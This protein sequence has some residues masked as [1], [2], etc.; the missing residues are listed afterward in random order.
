ML[1]WACKAITRPYWLG[2]S[3]HV[4]SYM[5]TQSKRQTMETVR[6]HSRVIFQPRQSD[7]RQDSRI[8]TAIIN[9]YYWG[10]L[11]TSKFIKCPPSVGT[12]L[13]ISSKGEDSQQPKAKLVDTWVLNTWM[14]YTPIQ[15]CTHS[16]SHI[17]TLDI[18]THTDSGIQWREE[19]DFLW[20]LV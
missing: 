11:K 20:E 14:D 19:T 17:K 2:E 4:L 1:L 18:H 12:M 8:M 13:L 7:I 9:Y 15:A 3:N 16:Q 10:G 6:V 5:N